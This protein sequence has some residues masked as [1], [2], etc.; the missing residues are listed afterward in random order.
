MRRDAGETR[1]CGQ[2]LQPLVDAVGAERDD[3][4]GIVRSDGGAE[5][6]ERPRKRPHEQPE[7]LVLGR[8]VRLRRP[9][10]DA[11]LDVETGEIA[12]RG[13]GYRAR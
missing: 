1:L 10:P 7:V 6:V 2:D 5:L 11:F 9:D 3:A 4:V 8:R 13:R 12:G